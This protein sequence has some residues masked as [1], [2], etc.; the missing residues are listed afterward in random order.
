MATIGSKEGFEGRIVRNGE[1]NIKP[2][3]G[4]RNAGHG[5]RSE[6][7]S[8]NLDLLRAVIGESSARGEVSFRVA[9]LIEELLEPELIHS[10]RDSKA[11]FFE[12][13]KDCFE[14]I[15]FCCPASLR[16]EQALP[17]QGS[18]FFLSSAALRHTLLTLLYP[19]ARECGLQG[20]L[21]VRTRLDSDGSGVLEMEAKGE[22]LSLSDPLLRI[23][24]K[25]KERLCA[26]DASSAEWSDGERR[27][28]LVTFSRSQ[29]KV[30]LEPSVDPTL[31]KRD[32]QN[33]TV[34]LID[35]EQAVRLVG[36]TALSRLG[37]DVLLAEDGIEGVRIY[38]ERHGEIDL[39][40]LDL[41]M[42]NMGGARCLERMKAVDSKVKVILMSGFTRNCKLN[43]LMNQGCLA[44]LR[45][46]FELGELVSLVDQTLFQRSVAS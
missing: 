11:E 43:D 44:F 41:V 28:T 23:R 30:A 21:V 34:L 37:Y 10:A 33:K 5:L 6:L 3:A 8:V 24:A 7:F 18:D 36:R 20:S 15:R 35:D 9:R 32:R 22:T 45:K 16:L 13:C 25:T 31:V 17:S 1:C 27:V 42:P 39:V 40:L 2:S 38:E 4:E 46:P 19:G 14:I 26:L 12:V 29:G